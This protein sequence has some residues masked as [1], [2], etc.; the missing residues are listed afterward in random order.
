MPV[1]SSS[2]C[3]A[4]HS[5]NHMDWQEHPGR[6]SETSLAAWPLGSLEKSGRSPSSPAPPPLPQH[7]LQAPGGTTSYSQLG[8][9]RPGFSP[10]SGKGLGV[11]SRE[12]LGFPPHAGRSGSW[13]LRAGEG[14][15]AG[16]LGSTL[17]PSPGLRGQGTGEAARTRGADPRPLLAVSPALGRATSCC[18]PPNRSPLCCPGARQG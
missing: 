11:G 18:A 8:A 7:R 1:G 16:F 2:P 17:T 13:R 3:S 6:C 10:S 15:E 9:Q 14:W 4:W 5:F 12:H